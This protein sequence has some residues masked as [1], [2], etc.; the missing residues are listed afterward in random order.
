VYV[1]L[2]VERRWSPLRYERWLVDS[3]CRLLLSEQTTS[4][5]GHRAP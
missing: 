4:E 5:P 1:M 2:T 3:W